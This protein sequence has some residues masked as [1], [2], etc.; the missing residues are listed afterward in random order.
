M[1]NEIITRVAQLA[2][3]DLN[4][5]ELEQ[6]GQQMEKMLRHFELLASTDTGTIEPVRHPH[7]LENQ[8]REDVVVPGL[9]RDALVG[10]SE[11]HKDGCLLVPRT[12]E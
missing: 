11:R 2:R 12:V 6:A 8:L 5:Q 9:P 1:D 7:N 4:E 3:L 10:L